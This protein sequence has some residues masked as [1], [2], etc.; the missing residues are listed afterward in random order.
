MNKLSEDKFWMNYIFPE[1][2][3]LF[4]WDLINIC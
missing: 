3:T 2:G 4:E 1:Q